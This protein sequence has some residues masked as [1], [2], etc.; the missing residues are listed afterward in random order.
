MGWGEG[1]G[2]ERK[3]KRKIANDWKKK[4]I[5]NEKEKKES[6][7]TKK[8]ELKKVLYKKAYLNTNELNIPWPSVFCS[9]LYKFKDLFLEEV[10]YELP[11]IREIEYQIDFI[12]RAPIPNRSTYRRNPKESKELQKQVKE[13]MAKGYV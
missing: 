13:S 5:E 10:S 11:P 12:L 9:L 3:S 7:H 8:S 4:E 1:R 6:Y 2:K